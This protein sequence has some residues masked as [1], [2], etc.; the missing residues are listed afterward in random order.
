MKVS[1]SVEE[2]TSHLASL[3]TSKLKLA[4]TLSTRLKVDL[5][6][7]ETELNAIVVQERR[8][9]LSQHKYCSNCSHISL[10]SFDCVRQLEAY[11]RQVCFLYSLV[12][13]LQ[14]LIVYLEIHR[15]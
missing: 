11:D 9:D 4:Q 10:G 15:A 5:K 8:T 14:I 13:C 12:A 7:L 1:K 2:Q 6:N 3:E